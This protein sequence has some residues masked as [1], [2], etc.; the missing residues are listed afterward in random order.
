MLFIL[1]E[2]GKLKNDFTNLILTRWKAMNSLALGI[3][4]PGI[5]SYELPP[6]KRRV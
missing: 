3:L 6:S 2:K 4:I 1:R 5:L